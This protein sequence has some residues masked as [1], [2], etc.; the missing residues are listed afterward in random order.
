MSTKILLIAL[1]FAI[2]LISTG[3]LK[4]SRDRKE[5]KP[6]VDYSQK[7]AR[8]DK[9]DTLNVYSVDGED[10][11]LIAEP[12]IYIKEWGDKYQ[13]NYSQHQVLW[14]HIVNLF[15][16]KDISNISEFHILYI[17][18]DEYSPI[19][20]ALAEVDPQ[21]ES[22]MRLLVDLPK[23]FTDIGELNAGS[24]NPY[25]IRA[26]G[27]ILLFSA[28]NTEPMSDYFTMASQEKKFAR[29][30]C[31]PQ[32]LTVYGCPLPDSPFDK[33]YQKFWSEIEKAKPLDELAE[34]AQ[35]SY[36]EVMAF[37]DQFKDYFFKDVV[38]KTPEEDFIVAF[39]KFIYEEK[40]SDNSIPDQK[41]KFFYQ[42]PELVE[43]REQ[44]RVNL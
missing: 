11:N 10:I 14:D 17:H 7:Y 20:W 33:Y 27:K 2:T 34:P 5:E 44:V 31:E 22:S 39:E 9:A 30:E 6:G 37:D 28:D 23:S 42:Y 8:S 15:P 38:A 16:M 36:G 35:E 41:I 1:V 12:R 13:E 3:C 19:D 26:M 21:D 18:D 25:L 32:F 29:E 24:L 40:P 43:I 4:V